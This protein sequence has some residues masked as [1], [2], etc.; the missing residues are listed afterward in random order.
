MLVPWILLSGVTCQL[1]QMSSRGWGCMVN[2]ASCNGSF[3]LHL[4]G[5]SWWHHQ[6]ETFS[7]LLALWAGNSLLLV[8]SSHKDQW[9]GALVFSLICAWINDWVNNREAGDL[10]RHRGHYNVNVKFK[11]AY[12][13][14]NIKAPKLSPANKIH[15]FQCLG[16]ILWVEFQMVPLKFHTKIS[17]PY[18][19][20]CN[21]FIQH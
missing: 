19:E 11:D 10:R 15:I 16:K 13:L 8:N 6:M 3:R 21:F 14:L 18:I 9:R 17:Y 7:V 2:F 12:K 1:T 20:R 5:V 4:G